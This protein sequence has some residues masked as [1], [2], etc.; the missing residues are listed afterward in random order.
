MSVKQLAM[1]RSRYPIHQ[2]PL[3]KI[4]GKG[5]LERVLNIEL[6]KLGELLHSGNYR[7]WLNDKGREIQQ[8][9]RWLG[10]V[11]K[12]V[13]GLLSRIDLPEYVFSQKGRSYVDNACYHSGNVPLGKT[14]ISKFYPST[15]RQMVRQM[16]MREF[17]C[18]GD[19]AAILA[20]IC[21]Y[22]QRHLPTGSPISGR[23]A[24]FAAKPMFDEIYED[25]RLS[26]SRMT[27]YVDDITLSGQNVTKRMISDV[28]QTVRR[29]GL[30]TKQAKSK[31]FPASAPKA[32]TGTMVVGNEVKLPN[33]RHK[34]IW[35]TKRAIQTATPDD[36]KTLL[37]SLKGRI[38]EASQITTR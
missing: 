3:Y 26:G 29:H 5:K 19:V 35:D 32:V 21:C 24:F 18:A 36:R 14:D 20:D 6:A 16:F 2:S 31:T 15:T 7:V 8:P 12:R 17:K 13:G 25:A 34:K 28:R 37:K 30:K 11:H 23:I 33:V 1:K 38:Q 9:I 10:Q 4:V 27:L 22:Q